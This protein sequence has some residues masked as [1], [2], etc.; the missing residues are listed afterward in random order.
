MSAQMCGWLLDL[1]AHAPAL[2]IEDRV[3]LTRGRDGLGHWARKRN[4]TEHKH[5]ALVNRTHTHTCTVTDTSQEER[6]W[7]S[8]ST[9][10]DCDWSGHSE[11][12]D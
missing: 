1:Y 5:K 8:F 10:S 7:S 11:E 4:G 12:I 6:Y 2:K 9:L 3:H